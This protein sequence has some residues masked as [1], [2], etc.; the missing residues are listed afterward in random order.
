VLDLGLGDALSEHVIFSASVYRDAGRATEV[1]AGDPTAARRALRWAVARGA[2]A[3]FVGAAA[4]SAAVVLG[5]PRGLAARRAEPPG[6]ASPS[7]GVAICDAVLERYETCGAP[8]D[9]VHE[10]MMKAAK[11]MRDA[12]IQAS[13]TPEG[14]KAVSDTCRAAWRSLDQVPMCR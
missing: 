7:T 8:M 14:R 1:V 4:L 2:F 5:Y 10:E 6:P 11:T 12:F 9:R 13:A 3:F